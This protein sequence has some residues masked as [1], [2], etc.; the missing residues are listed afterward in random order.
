M[1]TPKPKQPTTYDRADQMPLYTPYGWR[2]LK[3]G[4]TI[5]PE[6]FGTSCDN[7]IN[8]L[9]PDTTRDKPPFTPSYGFLSVALSPHL[10]LGC[11]VPDYSLLIYIRPWFPSR[12]PLR[13]LATID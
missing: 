6:D 11:A 5:R 13:K 8:F 3:P 1:K 10:G 9:D 2:R 12:N 4:E 7:P